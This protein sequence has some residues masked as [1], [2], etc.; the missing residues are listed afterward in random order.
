MS[1]KVRKTVS[2]E[3]KPIYTAVSEDEALY[4]L[5]KSGTRSIDHRERIGKKS[6]PMFRFTE[7]ICRAVYTANVIESLNYSLSKITKTHVIFPSEK[8]ALKPRRL[9]LRNVEKQRTMPIQNWSPG[10][11]S[12]GDYFRRTAADSGA[13]K[14]P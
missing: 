2:P 5:P 9:G 8:A 11:E 1:Y 4:Y 6:A 7:E 10:D 3:L 14:K 12:N 13:V